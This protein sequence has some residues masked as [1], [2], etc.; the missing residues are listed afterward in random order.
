MA[1][2]GSQKSPRNPIVRPISR[3]FAAALGRA[4]PA[5]LPTCRAGTAFR[6]F[7]A[8]LSFP[9]FSKLG[10][11]CVG[12]TFRAMLLESL[13]RL[14]LHRGLPWVGRAE[15][16]PHFGLQSEGASGEGPILECT[17]GK[18]RAGAAFLRFAVGLLDVASIPRLFALMHVC[19]LGRV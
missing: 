19:L 8:G 9:F 3:G 5:G 7:A 11:A 15:L 6:K 18:S 12:A 14:P 10:A 17:V 4:K 16:R 13:G 1:P 2:R